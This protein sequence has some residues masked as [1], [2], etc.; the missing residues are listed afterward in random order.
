M[1]IIVFLL[2]AIWLIGLLM[3]K[4]GFI[5]ILILNAIALAVVKYTAVRRA[6]RR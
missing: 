4:G 2:F 5:H 3:G 6:S 1:W